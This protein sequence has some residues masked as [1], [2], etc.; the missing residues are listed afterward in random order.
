MGLASNLDLTSHRHYDAPSGQ[1]PQMQICESCDGAADGLNLGLA[2][3]V[4]R[5]L[6]PAALRSAIAQENPGWLCR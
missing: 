1:K 5:A 3:N 2:V 6:G 4:S